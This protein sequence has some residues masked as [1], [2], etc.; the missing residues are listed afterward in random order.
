[1]CMTF[2]VPEGLQVDENPNFGLIVKKGM[3]FKMEKYFFG[4]VVS[5]IYYNVA[6][7]LNVVLSLQARRI[8]SEMAAP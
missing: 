6:V 3:C 8:R 7:F 2:R 5:F 1:M 4:D